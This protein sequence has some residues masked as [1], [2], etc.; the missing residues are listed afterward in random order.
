LI[1]EKAQEAVNQGLVKA[2]GPG[3]FHPQTGSRMPMSLTVGDKVVLPAYGGS[4][5][6]VEG[7]ELLIFR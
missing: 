7:E 6:K 4:T 1:P 5:V 2:I 3:G